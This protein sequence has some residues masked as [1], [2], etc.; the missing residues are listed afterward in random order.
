MLP[1]T[2]IDAYSPQQIAERIARHETLS[3]NADA[4]FAKDR[5]LGE[6][7]ADRVASFG[8]S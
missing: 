3:T 6:R 4:E 2:L 8:G 5:S 1:E 7:L